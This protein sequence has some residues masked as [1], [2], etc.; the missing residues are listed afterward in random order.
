MA[1]DSKYCTLLFSAGWQSSSLMPKALGVPVFLL[2]FMMWMPHTAFRSSGRP[3]ASLVVEHQVT[4]PTGSNEVDYEQLAG[5]WNTRQ[6]MENLPDYGKLA[7]LENS[8][9]HRKFLRGTNLLLKTANTAS[10]TLAIS[11]EKIDDQ[12]QEMWSCDDRPGWSTLQ[13]CCVL[14]P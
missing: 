4:R 3:N 12:P 13:D 11:S 6:N 9:D 8:P 1:H 7:R 10:L 5:I 14:L 2:F